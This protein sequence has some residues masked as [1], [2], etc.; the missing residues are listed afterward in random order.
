[1]SLVR[2]RI[3]V[4]SLSSSEYDEFKKK[5]DLIAEQALMVDLPVTEFEVLF[6]GN[7][8]INFIKSLFPANCIFTKVD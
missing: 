6:R 3:N 8:N 2:Y 1:M 5:L 4:E 7:D